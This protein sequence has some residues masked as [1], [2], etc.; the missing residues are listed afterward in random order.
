MPYRCRP[1]LYSSVLLF[2]AHALPGAAT[3]AEPD[4]RETA[5]D[6]VW[7][8]NLR[9]GF[10]QDRPIN[11]A[12]ADAVL[13]LK[14]PYRAEDAT[15]VP[16]SI[17][18]K[19]EQSDAH[20]IRRIHVFIDKNPVPLVGIFEF[21]PASG[22]ADLAMRVRVDDFSFIRAIAETSS[23]ELFM[24]KSFVRATGA[25]SAPPPKSIEDSI[26]N[27][28]SMRIR[29]VGELEFNKPNLVQLMIKHPNITGL[30]PMSIGSRV[31]PPAHFVRELRVSYEGTEVMRAQL[32]FSI[33][34]DPSFRFFFLPR[35]A[36]LMT[37]EAVDTQDNHWTATQQIAVAS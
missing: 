25:C 1:F 13:E 5:S 2:L 26:A 23:G 14:A 16:I 19:A 30:Q 8:E 31:R 21:T 22:R 6:K 28:G 18:T 27:I 33:S 10:F 36:G 37:V 3:V 11:E 15:V 4:F 9:P 12:S 35:S 17:L 32:T 34:M 29:T 20:F 24:V 7:N